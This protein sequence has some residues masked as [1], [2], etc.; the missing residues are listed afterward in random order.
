MAVQ[1]DTEDKIPT[2]LRDQYDSFAPDLSKPDILVWID[3]DV[4]AAKL[5]AFTM[6]G[7]LSAMTE[8]LSGFKTKQAEVEAAITAKAEA[9]LQ[10]RV[11]ELQASGDTSELAKIQQEQLQ[12]KFDAQ[13]ASFTALQE[14]FDTQQHE[15]TAKNMHATA[16][17]LATK[18]AKPEAIQAVTALIKTMRM[19][20]V[21]GKNIMLDAD[22]KAVEFNEKLYL[23]E[24]NK[25]PMFASL[26]NTAVTE[27]GFDPKGAHQKGAQGIPK[28][29][30]E[31][32]NDKALK[33][34]YYAQKIKS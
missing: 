13:N 8:Q 1:Y 9:K 16:L 14:K 15:A 19:K 34:L 24:L 3:K 6:Q 28:T 2:E 17:D 22:G 23:E 5:E 21:E 33:R 32:G 25:D 31:C 7:N 4:K 11:L 27:G 29:L 10:A 18:F 20:E 26:A 12:S 30:K